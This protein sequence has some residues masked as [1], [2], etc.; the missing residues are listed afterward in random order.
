MS[1]R[2]FRPLRPRRYLMVSELPAMMAEP[3]YEG[4]DRLLYQFIKDWNNWPSCRRAMLDDSPPH[5]TDIG[6]AAKIAVVVHALCDRDQHPILAWV[7]ESRAPHA[8][9]LVPGI[10]LDTGFGRLIRESAPDACALHRVYFSA[11]DLEST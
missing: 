6:T 2:P 3:Y 7:W 1:L 4:Q 8:T 5:G 11:E 10:G 9:I